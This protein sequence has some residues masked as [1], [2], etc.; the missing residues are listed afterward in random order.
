[1]SRM[2]ISAVNVPS[3][4]ALGVTLMPA[5]P[6]SPLRAAKTERYAPGGASSF[7]GDVADEHAMSSV[8]TM[9]GAAKRIDSSRGRAVAH[10]GLLVIAVPPVSR[11]GNQPRKRQ[12]AQTPRM[13]YSCKP[14]ESH[15]AP[16]QM[17]AGRRE[18]PRATDSAGSSGTPPH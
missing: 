17:G 8:Q 3:G 12:R 9:S 2:L 1:M 18:S 14:D 6:V 7:V 16:S 4:I 15:R 11:S 5:K 10:S 13:G